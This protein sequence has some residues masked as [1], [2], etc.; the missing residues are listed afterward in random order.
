MVSNNNIFKQRTQSTAMTGEQVNVRFRK[1]T[2]Q[3]IRTQAQR[4]GFKN[5]QAYIQEAVR[6]Q[7]LL[8]VVDATAGSMP[9][10]K[11]VTRESRERAARALF[12]TK[13][14]DYDRFVKEHAANQKKK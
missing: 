9:N 10:A 12:E 3:S 14:W 6:R 4:R 5:V 7:H 1:E 13:G 8:D 11:P 2:L